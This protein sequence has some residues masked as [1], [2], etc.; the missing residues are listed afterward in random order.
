MIHVATRPGQVRP[1]QVRSDRPDKLRARVGRTNTV[2]RVTDDIRLTFDRAADVYDKVRPSYP[3][4]LFDHLFDRL[5]NDPSVVEVGPGTGQATARL[6]ERGAL[7]T[8]VELGPNLAMTLAAKFPDPPVTVVNAPFESAEL[9][10]ASFDAVVAATAYHWVEPTQR[11]ERPN[12]LLRRGG[13]VA[14]IDLIQ[15]DSPSDGG[16]FERVQP[17]Y[18]AFGQGKS[19]EQRQSA[20]TYESAMPPIVRELRASVLFDEP[21]VQRI[22]WDQTYTS[23]QYR[24]LLLTYSGTQM[25]PLPQRSEMVAALIGVID[26]EFAGTVTRPLVATL[27]LAVVSR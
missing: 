13:L 25:M 6:I 19:T 17:I 27:T 1:G 24:D 22:R 18:D 5:P 23:Q 15:V 11:V 2:K 21:E 8:A 16:Y 20:E 4:E 26:D 7:V 3:P 14:I 9:S 10:L 12:A